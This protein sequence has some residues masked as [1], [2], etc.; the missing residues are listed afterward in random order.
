MTV[1]HTSVAVEFKPQVDVL[2]GNV[3]LHSI[4]KTDFECET[5]AAK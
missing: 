3:Q 4:L 1:L 5:V 2:V